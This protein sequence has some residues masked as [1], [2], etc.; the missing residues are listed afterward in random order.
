MEPVEKMSFESALAELDRV[1][2]RLEEG[3][4]DL[5]EAVGLY[6]RGCALSARCQQL[7]DEVTLKVQQLMPNQDSVPFEVSES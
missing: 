6:Q 4:L 7:L 3:T 5:E 1:V 2:S